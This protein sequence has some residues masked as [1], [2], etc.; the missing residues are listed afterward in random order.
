[1]KVSVVCLGAMRAHLPGGLAGNRAD[2]EVPNGGTV[3][4]AAIALGIPAATIHALLVDGVQASLSTPLQD[5]S[6][7]VLMPPFSGG[8]S[9]VAVVTVSDRVSRGEREDESGP[10]AATILRSAGIEV[11]ER[12]VVADD[13]QE[14][15]KELKRHVEAGVSLVVTTGGTG[16]A[17]R[18]V[19]PE[20]TRR[21]IEREAPG[22]AEAMRAAGSGATRYAAL[23][24]AV[25]GIAQ[26]TLIV[27]L[28]GST[29]GVEESLT[30]IM[31]A[32]PHALALLQERRHEHEGA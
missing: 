25:A 9:S 26:K 18:D 10:V 11:T 17:P 6:E 24:R 8:S 21:V 29:K 28:P 5:G 19:T 23:S 31:Q 4:D 15:E 3:A 1:M 13:M 2:V 12:S 22:L 16:F 30:A 14:I 27:N 7:L 32:L 20:A